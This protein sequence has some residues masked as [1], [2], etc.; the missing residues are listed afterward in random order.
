MGLLNKS[1]SFG[2]LR[3][4]KLNNHCKI[5]VLLIP[6]WVREGAKG[7][8]RE[9]QLLIGAGCVGSQHCNIAEA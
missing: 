4:G 1:L 9:Q 5:F 8:G 6:N 3:V 7:K 2:W